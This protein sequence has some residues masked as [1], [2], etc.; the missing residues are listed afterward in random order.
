[1]ELVKKLRDAGYAVD[2]VNKKVI[3]VVYLFSVLEI[4]KNGKYIPHFYPEAELL[5]RNPWAITRFLNRF[6]GVN[7]KK[8]R[9]ILKKYDT[10][11]EE[12]K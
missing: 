6:G 5:N 8:Q 1:M 12:A 3:R 10:Y 11:C 7:D 2:L 9:A 4:D